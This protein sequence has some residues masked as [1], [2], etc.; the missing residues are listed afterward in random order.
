MH[1]HTPATAELADR[2]IGLAKARVELD[3]I[4]L[5]Y[6]KTAEELRELCGSTITS[7]G[8]GG[9]KAL[10]L[11]NDVLS[12]ASLSVD[13]TRY[14][15]FVPAA[16]TEAAVLFDLL[17]SACSTYG[18]SWLEGAGSVFAENEALDW[19]R[20]IAGMPE[21]AGGVFVP[22]GTIGN[23]SAMV[24]A[25]HDANL[26]AGD[27]RPARWAFLASKETHSSVKAACAV[28]DADVILV[29]TGDDRRMHGDEV[30]AALAEHGDRVC[31]V[32]ATSGTT[33]L[34]LVDD[35]DTIADACEEFGV[36]LHVDGAY[37]GAGLA[38]ERTRP[39]FAGLGRADSFI[40][41]PHKWLFAPFD[42]C[43]LLYKD[44][45]QAQAIHAQYAGYLSFLDAYGDWNPSDFA[46]HLTRRVRGLPFW[47]S[48]ATHGT[49]AYGDAIDVT[50]DLAEAAAQMII[51]ADHLELAHEPSLSVVAFTRPGWSPAEYQAWTEQAMEKGLAFVTPSR[52]DGAP[53][54]RFCFVNPRT[55]TDEIAAILADMV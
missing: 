2:I 31:C 54:F 37:G 24:A 38:S 14:L 49:A 10:D 34:G 42:C 17:V 43:A 13:F 53:I 19:I 41:D 36:W 50:L 6:P 5:E 35:L 22:G 46:I 44:P 25:R 1:E 52:L 3:P 39:L 12:P 51:D 40:V 32:V 48:L 20:Q 26:R 33:N 21:G 16:P 55:T 28:M 27:D 23:L 18:G 45:T 29:D 30:R 47:F 9:D 8:I 4:P 15:A 11:F 7:D